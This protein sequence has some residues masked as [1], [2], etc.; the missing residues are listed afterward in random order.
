M[1]VNPKRYWPF[2]RDIVK[3]VIILLIFLMGYGVFRVMD[4]YFATYRIFLGG[5]EYELE[6]MQEKEEK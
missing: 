6:Q 2:W 1:I 5:L 4:Q 3:A